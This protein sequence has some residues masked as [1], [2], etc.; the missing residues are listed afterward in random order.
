[1]INV[2]PEQKLQ[3]PCR[4]I[5]TFRFPPQSDLKKGFTGES[6]ALPLTSLQ[7]SATQRGRWF[8][9]LAIYYLNQQMMK[10]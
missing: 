9:R 1:M 5:Q 2:S 6:N 8:A 4:Q 10:I 7:T 3:Q